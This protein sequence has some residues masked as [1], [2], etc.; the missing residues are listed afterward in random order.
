[1]EINKITANVT[2]FIGTISGFIAMVIVAIVTYIFR[3]KAQKRGH[4]Y[5]AFKEFEK[6]FTL[7]QHL[8]KEGKENG[9]FIIHTEFPKHKAAMLNFQHILKGEC[10]N[11]FTRKWE[12][13]GKLCGEYKAHGKAIAFDET[14]EVPD[15]FIVFDDAEEQKRDDENRK[16]LLRLIEEI[17]SIAKKY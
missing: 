4:S 16:T 11:T 13:Y 1:M 15:K 17:L 3:V 10:L 7:A 8:L 6:A 12:E 5:E 2:A 9:Y 14:Q